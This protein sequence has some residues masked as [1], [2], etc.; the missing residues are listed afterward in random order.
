M[1]VREQRKD[2]MTDQGRL[3]RAC[4]FVVRMEFAD[5]T[6]G[7]FEKDVIINTGAPFSVLPYSLWHQRNLACSPLGSQFMTLSG[8][9]DPEALKW[10][11]VACEF[12]ET[13]AALVDEASRRSRPLRLIAELPR[14]VV[15]SHLEGEIILG[16]N[17]LA[18][19]SLTLT[20]HP[21]SRT[22]AGSLLNVVGFLT[23]P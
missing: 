20:V 13:R 3:A 2:F 8:Q 1:P 12:G 21:G 17:F 4:R 9:P 6:R 10:F 23:L 18:D 14:S 7:M 5:Q 19:N 15:A 11:G 22:T 16:C